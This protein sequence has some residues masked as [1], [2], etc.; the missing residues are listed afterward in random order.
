MVKSKGISFG[1]AQIGIKHTTAQD[2]KPYIHILS[3]D[4]WKLLSFLKIKNFFN[5]HFPKQ[6]NVYI[7]VL[8]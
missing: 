8:I 1:I 4:S 7:Y 2:S 3:V 5:F 6:Q